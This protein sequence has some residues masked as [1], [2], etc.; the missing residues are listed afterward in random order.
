MSNPLDNTK[1]WTGL[2]HIEAKGHLY[3][4]RWVLEHHKGYDVFTTDCEVC[5][6]KE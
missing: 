5:G 6:G 4:E 3:K 2:S 1:V